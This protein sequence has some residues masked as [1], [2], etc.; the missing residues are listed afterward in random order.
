MVAPEDEADIDQPQA[1]D[2]DCSGCYR[3]M[4]S[5]CDMIDPTAPLVWANP[6]KAAIGAEIVT[7][8]TGWCTC[9]STRC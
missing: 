9:L 6:N 5:G 3:P 2:R 1:K 7:M 8:F 4:L